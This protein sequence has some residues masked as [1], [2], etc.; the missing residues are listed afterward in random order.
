ME[1][2][3]DQRGALMHLPWLHPGP[4][5]PERTR[6]VIFIICTLYSLKSV[7][8]GVL[9]SIYVMYVRAF[10]TQKTHFYIGTAIGSRLARA[11]HVRHALRDAHDA[12]EVPRGGLQLPRLHRE[13]VPVSTSRRVES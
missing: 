12:A 4:R 5:P 2:D 13:P 6:A 7:C 10:D 3:R 1:A 9:H 8:K 11:D